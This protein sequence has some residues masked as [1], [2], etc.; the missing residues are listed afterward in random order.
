MFEDIRGARTFNADGD[1]RARTQSYPTRPLGRE[2]RL[3]PLRVGREGPFT[4]GREKIKT[5]EEEGNKQP[6]KMPWVDSPMTT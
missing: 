2:S 1:G 3:F 5:K 4:K 6:E